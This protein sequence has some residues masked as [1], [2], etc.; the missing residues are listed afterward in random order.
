MTT[1]TD[2]RTGTDAAYSRAVAGLFDN[3]LQAERAVMRLH[4]GGI[5]PEDVSLIE[6]A[7][8]GAAPGSGEDPAFRQP[9]G[10]LPFPDEDRASYAEGLARGGTLVTA[11]ALDDARHDQA[12]IIL[13][14]EGAVDLA[15]REAQWRVQGWAGVMD[16]GVLPNGVRGTIRDM[17]YTNPRDGN[18][19]YEGPSMQAG[20]NP[21]ADA[22]DQA[23]RQQQADGA[24]TTV[25]DTSRGPARTR[26]YLV[27][28]QIRS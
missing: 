15:A 19:N 27:G 24:V 18:M 8:A 2:R 1:P 12:L 6:G 4:Q 25:R 5:G 11:L 26:S 10:R 23:D 9:V 16:E 17:A 20:T 22:P 13:D 28:R 14:E 21:P 7:S 3:R